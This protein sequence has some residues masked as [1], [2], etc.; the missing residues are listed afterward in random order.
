[1][2]MRKDNLWLLWHLASAVGT[3]AVFW[4]TTLQVI[5]DATKK[6]KEKPACDLPDLETGEFGA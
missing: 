5:V 1:M 4:C 3:S 6:Q 2:T